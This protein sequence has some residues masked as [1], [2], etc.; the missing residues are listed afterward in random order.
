MPTFTLSVGELHRGHYIV[1]AKTLEEA[2]TS[3]LDGNGD[4]VKGSNEF[5]DL[6]ENAEVFEA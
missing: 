1:E 5:V 4:F 6:D 2:I 3:A